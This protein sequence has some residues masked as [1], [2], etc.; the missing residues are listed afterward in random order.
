MVLETAMKLGR[1]LFKPVLA[2]MDRN[3]PQYINGEVKVHPQVR[4]VMREA[5]SG[6]WI[7]ATFDYEFGGSSYR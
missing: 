5:G 4:T 3:Q 6:G 2:E 1:D 7:G